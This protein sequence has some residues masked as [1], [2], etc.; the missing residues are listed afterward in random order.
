VAAKG[1]APT[2]NRLQRWIAAIG[3]LSVAEDE[4]TANT[5]ESN[6]IALLTAHAATESMLGL[7]IGAQPSSV[8][9]KEKFFP[10][11][12]EEARKVARPKFTS[13]MV[14]DM[15]LVHRARNGFLHAGQTV[16]SQ[17]VDVAI[18]VAH[19]LATRTTLPGSRGLVG[20]PT[21]VAD[22]IDFE[23]VGC[24]LRHSDRM[25][26]AGRRDLAADALGRALD[27]AIGHTRPRIIEP[28]DRS[29]RSPFPSRFPTYFGT[30]FRQQMQQREL[31][32]TIRKL[33]ESDQRNSD[34]INTMSRWVLPLALGTAPATY[35]FLRTVVGG[36]RSADFAVGRRVPSFPAVPSVA[37]LRRGAA[38]ISQIIFRLSASGALATRDG[39]SELVGIAN[40]FIRDPDDWVERRSA[41]VAEQ[42]RLATVKQEAAKA[43]RQAAQEEAQARRDATRDARSKPNPPSP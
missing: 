25:R 5:A 8:K 33:Q 1:I 32:D 30:D 22:I 39:D 35:D 26:V 43:K 23:V 9:A 37:D 20:V 31:E 21:V 18:G 34:A 41:W 28:S 16:G 6:A 27:E 4:R 14:A 24:W 15:L 29:W 38:E 10:E 17:E 42:Q 19:A 3:L 12:L 2:R 11:I 7:L 36:G 40:E 13:S